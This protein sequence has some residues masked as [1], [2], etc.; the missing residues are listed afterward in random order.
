MEGHVWSIVEQMLED[1]EGKPVRCRFT[2]REI[3][4]VTLWGI[5]HDRPMS[6]ACEGANWPEAVRPERLPDDS[7]VSRRWKGM[8]LQ[9]R[10]YALHQASVRR[11]GEVARDA[12]VDGRPLPVGGCSKDPDARAGRSA[13]GMGRGY[14]MHALISLKHV[15][16][17]YTIRPMNEAEQ[18]VA[19]GLVSQA[20]RRV[21]RVLGDGVYDS[22]RLHRR[23]R[24]AG[25]RLYTPLREKRVGR[26]QQPRRLQLFRLWQHPVGRRFLKLRDEVERAFAQT[27]NVGF[28]FKGLPPWARR[29]HR[30][31]RWMWG[32]NLLHHAWLLS[33]P[34]AA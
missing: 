20:P 27:T 19:L 15:I 3:L 8:V 28:G 10:A 33:K 18:T 13:G 4:R 34:R 12:V 11:F 16:L 1:V 32:K 6:W 14:K 26:R 25:K 9:D 7:T 24:E 21:T 17:T 30:V 22:M 31:F 29:E 5:M 2:D 23:L